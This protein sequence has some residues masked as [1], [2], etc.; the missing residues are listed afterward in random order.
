LPYIRK[1]WTDRLKP[2]ITRS[3]WTD[4]CSGFIVRR[5]GVIIKEKSGGHEMDMGLFDGG[6]TFP[7]Y[8]KQVG[9]EFRQRY[10]KTGLSEVTKA[11]LKGLAAPRKVVA[12][13]EGYCPDCVAVLPYMERMKEENQNI[14][15][16]VKHRTGNEEA[17][18]EAAGESRIPLLLSFDENGEPLSVFLEFPEKLKDEMRHAAI[19]D[20]KELVVKFR[21]GAYNDMIE[22]ALVD[23]LRI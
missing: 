6:V 19:E 20:K 23:L 14:D 17:L 11:K 22:E 9:P 1:A 3:I 15:Y 12:F 7:E 2:E 18:V 16:T 13:S 21:A 5:N 4:R 8:L 10:E